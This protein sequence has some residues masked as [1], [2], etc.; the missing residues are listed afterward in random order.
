M[1]SA[2]GYRAGW[3]T[4]VLVIFLSL[5]YQYTL[6]SIL[7]H[8][9]K[10][11]CLFINYHKAHLTLNGKLLQICALLLD[12]EHQVVQ[13]EFMCTKLSGESYICI[14]IVNLLKH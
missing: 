1:A 10:L 13:K 2:D 9:N 7:C 3:Y 8:I 5:L 6:L 11:Y 12:L 14:E 4:M